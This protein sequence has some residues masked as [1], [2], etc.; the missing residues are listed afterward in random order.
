M[1]VLGVANTKDSGACLIVDGHLVAAANEERFTREKLTRAF[2]EHSIRWLLERHNLKPRDIHAVGLGMWKGIDSWTT[3]PAYV[4]E[5]TERVARNPAAREAIMA[6][7]NGSLQS[8]RR[9]RDELEAGLSRLGLDRLPRQQCSHH[10]AHALTAFEFS[11]YERALVVTLDGR[12]DFVSGSVSSW[13]RGEKPELLRLEL[14]LDS[15]G[16]LY[17]WATHYLGFTPDRHEGKVTGL[18]ARG[19]PARCGPLFRRAVTVADGRLR[20]EIG[21]LYAPYMRAELPHLRES[22][23]GCSREDVAA[24]VQSVLESTVIDY[25]RWYLRQTGERNLCLAGGIFANVLLNERLRTLP[26]VDGFYVYPH[27]GDGGISAGGAAYAAARLG[28]RVEPLASA[29]LGPD[30]GES[31]CRNA[32]AAAGL[33]AEAPADLAGAVAALIHDGAVVGL[34]Q[35]RMEYGPRALGNRSILARATDA[36]INDDLNRRLNR[37]EFMPFAPVTLEEHAAGCYVGWRPG[38][39]ASYYMTSCYPCTDAMRCAS[40]AVVHVDGTARPQIV[41]HDINAIY[42]DILSAYRR[43]SGIPTIINTSFN[44]HEAPIVCTPEQAVAVL[45]ADGVDALAMPPFLVRRQG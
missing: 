9:Q 38:D 33:A 36:R 5:A 37:S 20:F 15:L 8:D 39:P 17:G 14:E 41:R 2:P 44:E 13:R 45:V 7:L 23:A 31:A 32:L 12:G 21:D 25:V 11:P 29:Y 16:A 18:A 30:F 4:A 22:L 28:D 40:P 43:L 35:G 42:Y 3:F 24:G 6:R 34:F 10:M 19:D 27:M 26:E 1:I